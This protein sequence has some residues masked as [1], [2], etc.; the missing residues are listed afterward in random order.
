MKLTVCLM[1][2]AQ[3]WF[4]AKI[5]VHHVHHLCSRIPYYRLPEVLLDQPKLAAVGRLMLRESLRC[6]RMILWD[7]RRRRL[8]SSR[9]AYSRVVMNRTA[10]W[11]TACRSNEHDNGRRLLTGIAKG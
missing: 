6:V 8:I 5:Q 2:V 3:R 4:T 7:E 9:D 10:L 11:Q 1:S